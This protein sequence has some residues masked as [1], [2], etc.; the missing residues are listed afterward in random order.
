[1]V[2]GGTRVARRGAAGEPNGD[3]GGCS[4]VRRLVMV[5]CM[6]L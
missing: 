6:A 4:H 3:D 5:A 2:A 1:M